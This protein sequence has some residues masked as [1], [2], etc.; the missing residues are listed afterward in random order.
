MS[1]TIVAVNAGP[2]MGWNTET[3]LSRA[4]EG[5]AQAGAEIRRFDLF[6]LERYT[7]C[8]SCFG[9]KKERFQGRC[10][11]RDGLTP[12]L[13]A[14][15]EADGLILASPNY[16]S[17]MTA[18]F[19]ALYER[20]IFQ[21]LTYN[22]QRP[23]CNARPVPVLLIMTSNAPDTA[24]KALVEDY[25]QTLSRFVGPTETLV[26]GNTLQLKDYTQTDWPWTMFDPVAKAR[27]HETV[28]P[29]ECERAFAMGRA[30]A[31]K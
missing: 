6:R 5:A 25:R 13:D 31:Q 3:L 12:V 9:C 21:N 8:I 11:C 17:N 27:R 15:R 30:L 16:L 28:F 26:S 22:L 2:R 14:I 19:R 23:C 4:A 7:G 29:A 18:S 1:K 10:V 20:L 24:Y